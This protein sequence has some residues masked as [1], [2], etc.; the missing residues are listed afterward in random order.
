MECL[1]FT[2]FGRYGFFKNHECNSINFTYQ[3]I[4]KPCIMGLLGAMIG[5]DGWRQMVEH[6]GKLEYYEVFK[7]SKISI[8]PTSSY[9]ET[10]Y[11]TINNATG[12][13]NISSD[14]QG[15]ETANIKRQIL[16]NPSY[17]IIIQKDGIEEKYYN[18]LKE[19]LFKGESVYRLCLG[20]NNYTANIKDVEEI[21]IDEYTEKDDIIVNSLIKECEIEEIYEESE[22]DIGVEGFQTHI[23][24]PTN[25]NIN[26]DYGHYKEPI[27][28]NN[29]YMRTKNNCKLYSFND[30][31]YYFM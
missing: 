28:Y 31:V 14:K 22:D 3:F 6:D 23:W 19:M 18:K 30:K 7:N 4:H 21:T 24:L 10:F 8:I 27:T 17:T 2:V 15:G 26:S 16:Q 11:E 29:F 1:K 5:L 13:T 9:Y 20:N 12:F 25:Y